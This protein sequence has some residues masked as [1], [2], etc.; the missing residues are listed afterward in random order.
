[1][2]VF[3]LVIDG[4]S[5]GVFSSLENVEDYLESQFDYVGRWDTYL[6]TQRVRCTRK[7]PGGG[8]DLEWRAVAKTMEVDRLLIDKR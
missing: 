3:V 5:V 7:D 8:L 1:M 2:E 4:W 6:D